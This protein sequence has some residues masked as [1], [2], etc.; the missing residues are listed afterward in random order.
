MCGD[1]SV[2]NIEI[3]GTKRRQVGMVSSNFP[4][5]SMWDLSFPI[6]YATHVP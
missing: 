3:L 2:R 4:M 6:R 1:I 5:C